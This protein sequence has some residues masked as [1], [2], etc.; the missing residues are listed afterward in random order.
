M[1]VE[2]CLC[3]NDW[4]RRHAVSTG[5]SR[6]VSLDAAV[7]AEIPFNLPA[8]SFRTEWLLLFFFSRYCDG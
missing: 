7:L 2:H 5:C 8:L 4:G 3:G 6:Y 1:G